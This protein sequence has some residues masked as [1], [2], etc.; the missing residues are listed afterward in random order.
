M[1]GAEVAGSKGGR[2]AIL[3]AIDSLEMI[4]PTAALMHRNNKCNAIDHIAVPKTWVINSTERIDATGL[5]LPLLK[6][7]FPLIRLT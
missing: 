4:V 3:L 2:H 6:V 5:V 1:L 7:E